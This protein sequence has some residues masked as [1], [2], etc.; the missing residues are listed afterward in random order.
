M[1]MGLQQSPIINAQN[2]EFSYLFFALHNSGARSDFQ[3]Q[4]GGLREGEGEAPIVQG[5]RG[6]D[7]TKENWR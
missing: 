6:T 3:L 4:I 1:K 2:L 5:G 7:R